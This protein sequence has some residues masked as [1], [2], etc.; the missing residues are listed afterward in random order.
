MAPLVIEDL[1]ESIRGT[2]KA[3]RSVAELRRGVSRVGDGD[4][5]ARGPDRGGAR[6][7]P[8]SC[9]H[10]AVF[11]HCG[12][13]GAGRAESEDSGSRG[14]RDSQDIRPVTG[15]GVG[16]ANRDV[17]RRE[18][19]AYLG[20]QAP[21][22]LAGKTPPY[23]AADDFEVDFKGRGTEAD[24]TALG[25]SQMGLSEKSAAGRN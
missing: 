8:G 24:L 7:G 10:R 6:G 17:C 23:F 1:P 2:K 19:P 13:D 14:V 9:A 22:F 5:P 3:L 18:W 11:R 25:R 16:P 12:R 4:G 20:N 21:A 15:R